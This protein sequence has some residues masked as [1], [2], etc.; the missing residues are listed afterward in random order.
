MCARHTKTT[1]L[2]DLSCLPWWL[3]LQLPPF[4]EVKRPEL[5]EQLTRETVD[6]DQSGWE[7]GAQSNFMI[8]AG[9]LG[10][11]V[12]SAANIGNDAY[13]QFLTDILKV[14]SHT[15]LHYRQVPVTS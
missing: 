15:D 8:A 14:H 4:E 3:V 12:R 2:E 1:Y 7:A 9:R 11:R 10:M 13:G 5:L 6:G